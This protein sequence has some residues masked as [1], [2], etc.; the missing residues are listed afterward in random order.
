M[1]IITKKNRAAQVAPKARLTQTQKNG[2]RTRKAVKNWSELLECTAGFAPIRNKNVRN[3]T[4]MLLENQM[5]WLNENS[6]AMNTSMFGP[7][8]GLHG[9]DLGNSDFYAPDRKSVV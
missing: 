3:N 7:Q 1:A 4:A 2:Q 8:N 5:R 6:P 9:G